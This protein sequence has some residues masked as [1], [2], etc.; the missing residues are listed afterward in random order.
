[1]RHHPAADGA[2][3][4]VTLPAYA[5]PTG[6]YVLTVWEGDASVV[7]RFVFRSRKE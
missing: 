6:D 1:M 4:M 3:A 5:L 7:A 2:P